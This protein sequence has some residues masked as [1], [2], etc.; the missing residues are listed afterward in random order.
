MKGE[1]KMTWKKGKIEFDDGTV[2]PADLLVREDGQVWNVR[3]HKDNGTIEEIDADK[4]AEK[5]GK[6]VDEV[7]PYTYKIED[8]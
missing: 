6:S 4:F 1:V 3:V 5:L 8:L 7:Y 2:Y